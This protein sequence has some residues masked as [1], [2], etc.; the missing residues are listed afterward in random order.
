MGM[1]QQLPRY[2]AQKT[3][4]ALFGLGVGGGQGGRDLAGEC[5]GNVQG[6]AIGS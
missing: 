2:L 3:L 4:L 6:T 5:R 1:L